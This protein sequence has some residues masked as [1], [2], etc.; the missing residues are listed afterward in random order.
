MRNT[1]K[2]TGNRGAGLVSLTGV[3]RHWRVAPATAKA[4]LA[5]RGIRDTGLRPNPT[6]R[7]KDVWRMEGTPD[8][9]PALRDAFR[10]PLLI[11]E[12]LG[13]L[14]PELSDRTIRRDLASGRWPVIALAERTRRVR[15]R[16]IAEELE[17]RAGKRPV[18][19]SAAS[20]AEA[21]AVSSR[22]G[23]VR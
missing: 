19:R 10:E 21:A 17:I 6:Y 15:A 7:W 13:A 2:P 11:P 16:D 9:A 5:A 20:E 8:V 3:A 12:D 18:R 14:F 1:R 22:D 4:I 23:H